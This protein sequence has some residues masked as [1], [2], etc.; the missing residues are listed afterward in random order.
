VSAVFYAA[1]SHQTDLFSEP[2][3]SRQVHLDDVTDRINTRLG[4]VLLHRAAE[5]QRT[6]E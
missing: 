5:Q 2:V 6:G 3:K 4:P 1:E